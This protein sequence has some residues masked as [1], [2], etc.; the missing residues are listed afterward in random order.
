[1]AHGSRLQAPSLLM[2]GSAD[3]QVKFWEA[4]F[5]KPRGFYVT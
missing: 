2:S 3:G 5:S 4:L 1:M